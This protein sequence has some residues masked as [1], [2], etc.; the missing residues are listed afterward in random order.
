MQ[1]E[2]KERTF[3]MTMFHSSLLHHFFL[4]RFI[5]KFPIKEKHTEIGEQKKDASK[6]M[7]S[8]RIASRLPR[9][10]GKFKNDTD[11]LTE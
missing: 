11:N 4:C 5:F 8:S 2:N 10:R 3:C 7:L 6:P 9:L 1:E